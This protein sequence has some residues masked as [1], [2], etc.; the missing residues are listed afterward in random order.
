MLKRRT[1]FV[2]LQK[3][4]LY[5]QITP[6]KVLGG[7]KTRANSTIDKL[8]SKIPGLTSHEMVLIYALTQPTGRCSRST[9]T[10]SLVWFHWIKYSVDAMRLRQALPALAVEPNMR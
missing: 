10:N 8:S 4:Y 6:N 5:H 2:V 9:R 7:F 1:L 3:E